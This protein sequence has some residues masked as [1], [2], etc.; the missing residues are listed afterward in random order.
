MEMSQ[1]L[2]RAEM[3]AARNP[4]YAS[5]T[6]E[7]RFVYEEDDA[8]TPLYEIKRVFE[9]KFL[10]NSCSALDR[11]TFAQVKQPK[12]CKH[13]KAPHKKGCCAAYK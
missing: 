11:G 7:Q 5:L 1:S 6:S 9:R 2:Q 13:C 10:K 4:L 3:R 12:F 8:E